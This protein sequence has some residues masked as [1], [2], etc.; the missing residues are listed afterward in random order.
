METWKD[1]KS[2]EGLYEVSNLGRVR[3]L[4]RID[5]SGKQRKGR[6]LKL[7]INKCGYS[8]VALYSSNGFRKTKSVHRIVYEAFVGDITKGKDINHI[9]EN[10]QNNR[11]E[12]L[13]ALTHI[14]NVRHGTGIERHAV[15]ISKPV[16][17]YTKDGQYIATYSSV[18]EA[19]GIT[20]ISQSHISQIVNG[21]GRTAGGYIW[22]FTHE[23]CR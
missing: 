12:N 20:G 8:M 2:Y 16:N 11:P 3:S 17:Q 14:E 4:D 22:R 21:K 13:E 6:L 5:R 18:S 10:K 7:V 15:I 1:V 19:M 9:D 23:E